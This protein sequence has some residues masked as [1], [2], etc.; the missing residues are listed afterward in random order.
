M[1]IQPRSFLIILELLFLAAVGPNVHAVIPAPDG[2]YSGG[3][4]ADGTNAL[5][6][7][8]TGTYNTAVG[9]YSLLSDANGKFNTG[10]GAGTLLANVGDPTTGHGVS[11]TATGAGALL[12]N[13]TGGYNTANGAFVLFNN[14]TGDHNVAVGGGGLPG[15]ALFSNTIGRFN[16]AVGEGALFSNTEGNDNTAIG[17][18]A[19]ADNTG[20]NENVAIG[21]SALGN[22]TGDN[23]VALG[24]LAGFSQTTGSNNVYIGTQIEGTAGESNACY[25]ASIFNQTSSGGS[26]VFV[27]ANSKLGTITSSKRFKEDIKPMDKASNALFALKP[28][29]FRYKK[30][31]DSAGRSQFGLVAEEV[32]QVNPDLV[33]RDKEGKPYSV[34]YD[35]VNAML[36]N[37]FL[38]E[39]R[40]VE[41]L[42]ATVAQQQ[43]NF[44]AKLAKQEKQI[45]AL[46]SGLQ[47]VSAQVEMT[48]PEQQVT[49]NNP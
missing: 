18:G 46:T 27:D 48:K 1:K 45:E 20:G 39:H 37:E 14:T 16:T 6:S 38:K 2:G 21:L 11:N 31:I 42:E 33:V 28:I 30:E 5:L 9:I 26:A 7:L 15:P 29:T 43:K 49:A 13:T 34:R 10:V 44:Q 22:S 25:I 32:E 47:K 12:S 40:K 35:Q 19:L 41:E 24:N 36:L 3:N 4:T 17:A 23:N 8:T